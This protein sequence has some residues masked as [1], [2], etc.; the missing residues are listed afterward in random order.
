MGGAHYGPVQMYVR[1]LGCK[2]CKQVTSVRCWAILKTT[3][4]YARLG[5]HQTK[6]GFSLAVYTPDINMTGKT[7]PIKRIRL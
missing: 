6:P 5:E 4:R 2:V 3:K 1:R 7:Y